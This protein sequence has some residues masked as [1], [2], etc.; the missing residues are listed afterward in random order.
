MTK[1]D[2]ID[3]IFDERENFDDDEEEERSVAES[4][5]GS[6][7]KSSKPKKKM[8]K[9][10]KRVL[11]LS[12]SATLIYFI[13]SLEYVKKSILGV[14]KGTKNEE[15]GAITLKGTIIQTIVAFVII[16]VAIAVLLD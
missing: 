1:G 4:D 7:S 15:T 3:E 9:S 13:L 14:F 5:V 10:L 11:L 12:G 16:S 8:W 6:F 2:S